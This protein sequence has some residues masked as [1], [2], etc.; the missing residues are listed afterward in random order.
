VVSA[1]NDTTDH[2]SDSYLTLIFCTN[3]VVIGLYNF[4]M[5]ALLIDF[6]FKS[7][8]SRVNSGFPW[9]ALSL[10][11]KVCEADSVVSLTPPT[12]SQRYY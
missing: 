9:S 12:T 7:S 1:V 8:H 3:V 6:L 2:K 11:Q 5:C 10:T 4:I